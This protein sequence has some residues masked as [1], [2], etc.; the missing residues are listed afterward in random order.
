MNRI[1]KQILKIVLFALIAV[2][3]LNSQTIIQ[4]TNS[5]G[6]NI[7]DVTVN[8]NDTS[9]YI[10]NRFGTV[11]IE[12]REII[13]HLK[14]SHVSYEQLDTTLN[15]S[16]ILTKQIIVLKEKKYQFE[17][18]SIVSRENLF[19]KAF[20]GLLDVAFVANKIIVLVKAK[21]KSIL[22]LYT[23]SG[24]YLST[25]KLKYNFR[26]FFKVSFNSQL[27]LINDKIGTQVNIEKDTIRLGTFELIKQYKENLFPYV[28]IDPEYVIKKEVKNINKRVNYISYNKSTLEK[29]E[30][31]EIYDKTAY[32][33]A[34]ES[35]TQII[36]DYKRSIN[37]IRE[38][39][40]DKGIPR[41]DIIEKDIW[42]GDLIDLINTNE[43][44]KKVAYFEFVE[45]K[46]INT[47]FT[48]L[49]NVAYI[50]NGINHELTIKSLN[51]N[52]VKTVKLCNEDKLH[53][54]IDSNSNKYLF[55]K[56]G[57][58]IYTFNIE[59]QKLKE[60]QTKTNQTVKAIRSNYLYFIKNNQT[61]SKLIKVKIVE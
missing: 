22:F 8:L 1:L 28:Y 51:S 59:S 60:I 20:W 35:Y 29:K 32:K 26:K 12:T 45:S 25:K 7:E 57:E 23:N 15:I 36:A 4:F 55:I 46:L 34:K 30:I 11:S 41:L 47:D 21:N 37:V 56:G 49:N 53:K 10:S 48:V 16:S 44:Q 27:H 54:F 24:E 2:G 52:K 14:I 33:L 50:I 3:E 43:M 9:F 19:N 39:D 17:P 31:I 18:I 40:I 13:N 61:K 5:I 38:N 58:K 6:E 42:K